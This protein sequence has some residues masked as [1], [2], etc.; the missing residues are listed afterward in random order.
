VPLSKKFP[1]LPVR[2]IRFSVT[3][4]TVDLEVTACVEGD[5]MRRRNG[6]KPAVICVGAIGLVQLGCASREIH[7]PQGHMPNISAQPDTVTTSN[8]ISPAKAVTKSEPKQA[9]G[10]AA[11]DL[12][13]NLP[14]ASSAP[15]VPPKFGQ[16][17]T[18][19]ERV[20]AV[21]ALYPPVKPVPESARPATG[22]DALSL[23]DLQQMASANSPVFVRAKA[24]VDAAYGQVVQ[25]GLH[26]NPT[27]GYQADQWQP[28]LRTE[29]GTTGSGNGQQGGFINQLIKTAGKL[30]LAQKVAGF[31]YINALV[32]V[33]RAQVDVTAAVRTQY[34]AVLVAQQG[35]EINRALADLADDVYK[36]QL[37]QVASGEA[38]GYE[39]LQ[40]F[41]QAEQARNAVTVSEAAYLASWKQLATAVGRPD[42]PLTPL[43]GQA[44][45]VVPVFDAVTVEAKILEQHTDLL[46]A[47]NTL[48]QAQVNLTLQKRLPIPDLQTNTY[49][50]YDNLAQTYQFGVQLGIQLPTS[51]RNQGNIRTAQAK[52]ARSTAD[53]IA[54][55]NDLTGKLAEAFGRY[56][57]H[58][59]I[60]ERYRDK[61][62]PSLTRGYRALVRRYQVEPEKV[63]FNDIVV[64]QQNLAQALQA[65][66]NA[67]DA[68]WKSVVD[69]ANLGQLDELYPGPL[70]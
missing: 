7:L 48:E 49:H 6:W 30:S 57:T 17:A 39:P 54:T 23:V 11:F 43:A 24:D 50:Q 64:A 13:S 2:I 35:V 5:G 31:D 41:A 15:I 70:K 63:S 46:T 12:P 4:A 14:G 34:F 29:P 22:L 19:A 45:A 20:K 40:L 18:Q 67:L 1:I 21:E 10:K 59:V 38:A 66:L 52:I 53:L 16:D 55:Q 25:A 47:R 42:L 58:R 27:V 32:A 3:I 62:I 65:Y 68:Q 36:L 33:R 60:A 61:I 69:V 51:D 37:K 9:T 28:W 56:N 26:P 8:L 44:D